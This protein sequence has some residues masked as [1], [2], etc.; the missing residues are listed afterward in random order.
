MPSASGSGDGPVGFQARRWLPSRSPAVD[1][2]PRSAS[3][4]SPTLPCARSCTQPLPRR[5]Y[6]EAL[7][8]RESGA[9]QREDSMRPET[10][11]LT[12]ADPASRR[13]VH[14]SKETSGSLQFVTRA[15][16]C[17]V[18]RGDRIPSRA[19]S[20]YGRMRIS[21]CDSA[22]PRCAPVEAEALPRCLQP[23]PLRNRGT[24]FV[25]PA[26]HPRGDAPMANRTMDCPLP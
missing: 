9:R 14:R 20:L 21:S 23:P 22:A 13:D 11:H 16:T 15:K 1:A 8:S 17:A 26:R 3:R 18:T 4:D 6:D 5:L 7:R 25:R 24:V 10:W 19:G 2:L 12:R